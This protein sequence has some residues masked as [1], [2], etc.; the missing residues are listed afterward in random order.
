MTWPALRATVLR[1]SHVVCGRQRV[2]ASPS[3]DVIASTEKSREAVLAQL[4][5]SGFIGAMICA[6][7]NHVDA[8]DVIHFAIVY[9]EPRGGNFTS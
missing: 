2:S 6:E 5:N 9:R 1:V 7:N 4:K 3:I 8:R